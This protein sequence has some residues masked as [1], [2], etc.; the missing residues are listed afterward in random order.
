M[1]QESDNMVKIAAGIV[2]YEPEIVRLK[3]NIKAIY[4]QVDYI[5]ITDNGSKNI[6]KIQEELTQ[7]SNIEWILNEENKGIATALNQIVEHSQ[8]LGCDWTLTLDDDS[9]APDYMIEEY[10]KY[11][12]LKQVAMLV[13]VIKDRS[14]DYID[15]ESMTQEP[16]E[17]VETAITSGTLMNNKVWNEVGGFTDALFIDYVDFDY[18][19]KLHI[20]KKRILRVNQVVLL[21]ELGNATE[22][23]VFAFLAD[24]M[25]KGSF[26]QR[27]AE[28]LRFTTNHSPKR[29]YYV[30]RNQYYYMRTYRDYIDVKR[31]HRGMKIG[32]IIKL[33]FEK[34]RIQKAKAI[35]KGRK[36][37]RKEN[38]F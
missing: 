36:D 6:R 32:W 16:Y 30:T 4:T 37:G 2:T 7:F 28:Q 1:E 12:H 33:L 35:L 22:I 20:A 8:Q 14:M 17:E 11:I 15:L 10:K 18:C 3:D 29:L 23:K 9:I 13:P 34:Q 21:H 5:I 26:I 38:W 24:C 31:L 19:M 27:K 25:P